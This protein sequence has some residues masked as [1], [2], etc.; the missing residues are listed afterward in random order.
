MSIDKYFGRRYNRSKYNC[1][2]FVCE[3]WADLKGNQLADALREM[4][5]PPSARRVVLS[6]LRAV[7][8]LK[9]PEDPCVVYMTSRLNAPHVGIWIRGKVL[10]IVD[11]QGV[12]YQPLDVASLGFK[13]VRFLAC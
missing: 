11:N 6:D 3:V 13:R 7:R 9:S 12:Q 1:A 10:H 5:C 8:F 2:H 4:L